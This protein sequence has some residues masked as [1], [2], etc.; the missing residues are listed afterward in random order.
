MLTK[1][2]DQVGNNMLNEILKALSQKDLISAKTMLESV[3]SEKIHTQIELAR[4]ETAEKM[5]NETVSVTDYNPKSV[6]G[7]RK[8]LLALYSKTKSSEHATAARKAGAT[9]SE[10]QQ[11]KGTK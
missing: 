4:I 11:A 5:F 1:N 9:Q 2:P 10:L 8:E 3:L 6:G 7:S